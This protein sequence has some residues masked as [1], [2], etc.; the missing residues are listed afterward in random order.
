MRAPDESIDDLI[1][2]YRAKHQSCKTAAKDL[3]SYLMPQI[4]CPSKL[5][6][7]IA[8]LIYEGCIEKIYK[9]DRALNSQRK[10]PFD[11]AKAFAKAKERTDTGA[12][13]RWKTF[14][15]STYSGGDR[16]YFPD[17]T[18]EDLE[19]Y[20]TFTR[21]QA[22]TMDR[23]ADLIERVSQGMKPGEFVRDIYTLDEID[24]YNTEWENAGA[25]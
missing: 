11:H 19:R 12:A 1:I 2:R 25:A 5:R 23:K 7:W 10:K 17:A 13:I 16:I 22:G 15:L 18:R 20:I 4:S 24:A 8:A 14:W 3:S 21:K 9:L 6:D